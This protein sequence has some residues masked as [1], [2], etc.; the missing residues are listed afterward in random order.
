MDT[1]PSDPNSNP[2][3]F[4]SNEHT[5]S[6]WA[7]LHLAVE[8]PSILPWSASIDY[9]NFTVT[10]YR[11]ADVVWTDVRR[12]ITVRLRFTVDNNQLYA[13]LHTERV[14]RDGTSTFASAP[15]RQAKL[16]EMLATCLRKRLI[17]KAVYETALTFIQRL[18]DEYVK[19]GEANAA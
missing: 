10:L 9:Q 5:V 8:A 3:S 7:A 1:I 11:E 6:I 12:S 16:R 2:M 14:D 18:N 19:L 17:T 15:C 4:R 13:S